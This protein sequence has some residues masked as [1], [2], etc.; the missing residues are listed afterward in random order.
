MRGHRRHAH[1]R[2]HTHTHTRGPH[3]HHMV[4]GQ[5]GGGDA[6][7][8]AAAGLADSGQAGIHGAAVPSSEALKG[9]EPGPWSRAEKGKLL[10]A[11]L[12]SFLPLRQA[13]TRSS[14]LGWGSWERGQGSNLPQSTPPPSAI[15]RKG[16]RGGQTLTPS[17]G[18]ALHQ[19]QGSAISH[20]L[21]TRST[22]PTLEA[23]TVTKPVSR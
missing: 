3:T 7:I 21:L 1:S 8:E 19:G 11:L 23:R 18:P 22:L 10:A 4:D 16:F 13:G 6:D 17:S 14:Q 20:T 9:K 5:G 15:P 12:T 2:T